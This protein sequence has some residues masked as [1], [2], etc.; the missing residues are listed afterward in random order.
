MGAY[1]KVKKRYDKN[2]ISMKDDFRQ[3]ISYILNRVFDVHIDKDI[4]RVYIDINSALSIL[5]RYESID[6]SELLV[7]MS[8][9]IEKFMVTHLDKGLDIIFIYT[10]DKS[11]VHHTV[12]P[13]WCKERNERVIL[14][15]SDFIKKLLINFAIY[16]SKNKHVKVL[17]CKNAHPAMVIKKLERFERTA[18]LVLSKDNVFRCISHPT[19]SLYNGV[20]WIQFNVSDRPLPDKLEKLK[21][22][23]KFLPY[24]LAMRGDTRNEYKGMVGM[25]KVRTVDYINTNR[26]KIVSNIEH[27]HSEFFDERL[28]LYDMAAMEKKFNELGFTVES[29]LG[30]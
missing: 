16:S 30:K 9:I 21:N 26:I 4:K 8:G 23:D 14:R 20:D 3:V 5:F 28:P 25:G 17:N 15:S 13:E 10:L 6:D 29:I 22:P 12:Y 27:K 7:K 24:Y 11:I 2:I 19:V 1:D 18:C